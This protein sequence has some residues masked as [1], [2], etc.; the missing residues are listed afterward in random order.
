MT[1]LGGV[2][3]LTQHHGG[4]LLRDLEPVRE[5]GVKIVFAIERGDSLHLLS[6]RDVVVRSFPPNTGF[7]RLNSTLFQAASHHLRYLTVYVYGKLCRNH[8][9]T[10]VKQAP[11]L[12]KSSE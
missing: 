3:P 10:T 8:V 12:F 1:T 2:L 9:C 6:P 7:S 4:A 5:I 11:N